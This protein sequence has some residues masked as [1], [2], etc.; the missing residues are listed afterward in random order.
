MTSKEARRIEA[1]IIL[2][3]SHSP[4]PNETKEILRKAIASLDSFGSL[5]QILTATRT[6]K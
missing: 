5:D 3:K 2:L 6:I 4:D 1:I